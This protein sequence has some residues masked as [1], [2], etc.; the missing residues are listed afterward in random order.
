VDH[1]QDGVALVGICG[2]YQMLG[3][4]INDPQRIEAAA[5][6]TPGLGL[7]P[8]ETAFDGEKAT[9]QARAIVAAGPG[10]LSELHGQAVEGYE[11]HMGCT[12][13]CSP[14]GP[15][16]PAG[17]AG[18][19]ILEIQSRNGQSMRAPDGAASPDGRV[20]GCYLHGLFANPTLRH[21]WLRSLGWQGATDGQPII[22]QAFERLADAVEAALDMQKLE[23]F[24]WDN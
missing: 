16:E 23:S 20:W 24:L 3:Q 22:E 12:A 9:Y 5:E 15:F 10:W 1:V 2:G 21:A 19:H 17:Q 7:L 11:I 18:P 14:S 8:V 6:T 4:A 13:F